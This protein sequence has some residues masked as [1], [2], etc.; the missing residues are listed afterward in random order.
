MIGVSRV[1]AELVK[2]EGA[3]STNDPHMALP[4]L[5]GAPAQGRNHAEGA[6]AR[7][8]GPDDLP[9]ENQR[10]VEDARLAEQLFPTAYRSIHRPPFRQFGASE[11]VGMAGSPASVRAKPL[12]LL[13]IAGRLLRRGDTH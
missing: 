2:A 13:S 7:P 1:R 3:V 12:L 6:P 11:T 9:I 5:V 8:I 10:S 4:R